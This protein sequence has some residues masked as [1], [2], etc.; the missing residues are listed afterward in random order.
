MTYNSAWAFTAQSVCTV[1]GLTAL[2]GTAIG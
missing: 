1:T 2:T